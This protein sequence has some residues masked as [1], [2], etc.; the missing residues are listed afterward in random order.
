[1]AFCKIC[2]ETVLEG[3]HLSDGGIL[4]RS[5]LERIQSKYEEVKNEIYTQQSKL[6]LLKHEVKRREGLG[7]KL[8]SIFLRPEMLTVEIE[9]QIPI[10]EKNITLLFNHLS[11]LRATAAPIY[12]YL[13]SY[14]PDWEERKC[15]VI[16]RDGERC[17]NCSQLKS[18]HLHHIKPLS[19]G[20]N[21]KITNLKLLCEHCHSKVHGGRYILGTFNNS[22]TAFSKRVS[23][24][25]FAINN[26]KRIKF[27]YIKPN[28]KNYQ[29][30]IVKPYELINLDHHKNEGSTLCVHGYCELRKDERTF[31]LKRMKN[32]KIL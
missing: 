4:H 15:Q 29:H 22:K 25:H 27:A 12:D 13:L 18:L 8:I 6:K 14:P 30:R 20:G 5:C 32:L 21:N 23:N 16:E 28:E 2:K 24:I 3:I 19:K 17:H 10:I 7:F 9:N 11:F 31:A 1:M 26:C